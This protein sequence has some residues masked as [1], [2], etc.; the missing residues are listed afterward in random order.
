MSTLGSPPV[1]LL[2]LDELEQAVGSPLGFDLS[3]PKLGAPLS[4][5]RAA[6]ESVILEALRHEPCVISFS[7]GRD[8][9]AVLCVAMSLAERH[10]LAPPI[11][12]TLRFPDAPAS[13]ETV[14][15]ER[16]IDELRCPEWIRITPDGSLAGAIAQR[17]LGRH[18]VLF[19]VNAFLHDPIL[20]VAAGGSLLSGI[21]GDELLDSSADRISVVSRS[22]RS[23]RRTD[24]RTIGDEILP[25][26]RRRLGERFVAGLS[27][28][29]PEAR[30]A[31]ADRA[32]EALGRLSHRWNTALGQWTADRYF[33]AVTSTIVALGADHAV[34]VRTPFLDP[35]V[36]AAV[37]SEAGPTGFT[38]RAA[39]LDELVGDVMPAWLRERTSKAVF[40]EALVGRQFV[41]IAAK[42]NGGGINHDL[43]DAARLRAEWE[44]GTPDGRSFLLMHQLIVNGSLAV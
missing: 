31:A 10:G 1:Q 14:W 27:W 26:R 39:A 35:R 5:A 3:T 9:S 17:V 20:E 16:I 40:D 8:S 28:L 19:P 43:V 34:S 42:W 25:G 30:A 7:G 29:T 18:G 4:S 32:G 13:D 6:L 41:Q 37:A 24:I 22:P 33:Q 36:L 2:Q 44:S 38:S 15:Q 12:V 21:G 11:P 23:F